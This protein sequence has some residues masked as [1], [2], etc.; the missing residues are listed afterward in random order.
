M[1]SEENRK[2]T[3]ANLEQREVKGCGWVWM[4]MDGVYL[5]VSMCIWVCEPPMQCNAMPCNAQ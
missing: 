2:P 3:T 1:P 4:G 5:G